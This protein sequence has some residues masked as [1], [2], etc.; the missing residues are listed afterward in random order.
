M[1]NALPKAKSL[2]GDKGYDADCFRNGLA[3]RKIE[4]CIP[5]QANPKVHVPHDTALYRRRHKIDIA[6]GT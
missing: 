6:D 2:L 5:S 1:I 3:E 4:A